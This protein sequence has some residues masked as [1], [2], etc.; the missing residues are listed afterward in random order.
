MHMKILSV[1][2]DNLYSLWQLELQIYH[3]KKL[4]IDEYLYPIVIGKQEEP[5]AV[6]KKLSSEKKYIHYYP[7]ENFQFFANRMYYPP[8]L[9]SYGVYKFLKQFSNNERYLILDCDVLFQ[10]SKAFYNL[11]TLNKNT[12]W[13]S[14][15]EYNRMNF[16]SKMIENHQEAYDDMLKYLDLDKNIVVEFEK[17]FQHNPYMNPAGHTIFATNLPADI[18]YKITKDSIAIYDIL[19]VKSKDVVEHMAWMASIWSYYYNIIKVNDNYK[20]TELLDFCWAHDSMKCTKPLIH[21]T[22]TTKNNPDN[23]FCK[24]DFLD[25]SPLNVKNYEKINSYST[26]SI[27]VVYTN[28]IREY[29][30]LDPVCV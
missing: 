17:R 26:K 28:L 10:D 11:F 2:E 14:P 27:S 29:W 18:Y 3:F 30:N 9:Q 1:A 22:G 20:S 24:M 23:L 25:S 8:A 16:Y 5:N 15:S 19:K 7:Y 12:I 4:G 13:S 6:V 21:M